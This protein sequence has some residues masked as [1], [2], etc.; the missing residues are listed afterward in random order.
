MVGESIKKNKIIIISTPTADESPFE[1][2]F[3]KGIKKGINMKK[4]KYKNYEEYVKCQVAAN[5]KKSQNV[6]AKE[7]NI[8]AIAKYLK[9]R[10]PEFGLCHGVR[11]GFEID[12]FRKYLP[13]CATWGSEIG[14]IIHP[15]TFKWDFNQ[16]NEDW[17]G[18]FDFI[19]SNSF[20]HAYDPEV[21][22]NIW[23]AQ[24]KPKGL[25]I[26]EYDRRQEHTGEISRKVNKTDP[27]SI[28]FNELIELV[29]KWIKGAKI[30]DILN[31]P[32][33]TQEWRKALVIEVNL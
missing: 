10:K 14:D 29:P 30:K 12:W 18:K 32:V 33:V 16:P 24:L 23:A 7:K 22:L 31:M 27:V 25:I 1:K 26:L 20:D 11:Q 2:W 3:K 19:Y 8:K 5:K 21:T 13:L 28:R 17:W 6:W 4:Y 9:S 15:Y